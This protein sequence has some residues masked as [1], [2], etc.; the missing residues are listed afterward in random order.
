LPTEHTEDT[1]K[2]KRRIKVEVKRKIRGRQD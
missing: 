2:E 1:E